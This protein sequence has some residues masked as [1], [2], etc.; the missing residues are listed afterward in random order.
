MALA[1]SAIYM[2]ECKDP[3]IKDTYIGKATH[4][5]SRINAHKFQYKDESKSNKLYDFIRKNGG[6]DNFEFKV[7][8]VL[9]GNSKKIVNEIEKEAILQFKPTLNTIN[10]KYNFD[11]DTR[12]TEYAK[13][14]REKNRERIN[15]QPC[16]TLIKCEC[17]AEVKKCRMKTHLK[18]KKHKNADEIKLWKSVKEKMLIK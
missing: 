9:Y 16:F 18:S 2:I 11:V 7:L 4:L 13:M 12:S 1:F 5:S 15:N 8:Q 3:S 14:W 10:V 17:G 6:W